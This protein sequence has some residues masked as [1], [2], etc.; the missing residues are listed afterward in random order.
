[1][2]ENS[3]PT[4]STHRTTGRQNENCPL[5]Q[6]FST[7]QGYP[8][9]KETHTTTRA[10]KNTIPVFQLHRNQAIASCFPLQARADTTPKAPSPNVRP[11]SGRSVPGVA[12]ILG[13]HKKGRS[14]FFPVRQKRIPSKTTDPNGATVQ[15]PCLFSLVVSSA[16]P[17]TKCRKRMLKP[18]YKVTHTRTSAAT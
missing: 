18:E 4:E 5:N 16:T 15:R 14:H 11:T 1:M 9:K 2:V 17:N 10:K 6:P 12:H 7:F 13:T 8:K 3:G